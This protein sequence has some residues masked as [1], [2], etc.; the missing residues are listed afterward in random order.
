MRIALLSH[1]S[2]L[3]TALVLA[4]G[5]LTACD[6]SPVV[7]PAPSDG[8]AVAP[9]VVAAA[10]LTQPT[11]PTAIA[12][13][14]FLQPIAPAP[15]AL[16]TPDTS[17]LDLL[18]VEICAH[19]GAICTP[20][21]TLD[22][23]SRRS[24]RLRLG[25]RGEYRTVWNTNGD[26]FGPG[27]YRIRVLASGGEIGHADVEIVDPRAGDRGAEAEWVRI[28]RKSS[29]PIS[30]V[31]EEGV[32]QRQGSEGGR[33]EL[34]NGRIALDIP[35]GALT[36]D[37]FFTATP[38]LN[39]PTNDPPLIP[40][41]AWDFGPDGLVFAQPVT[42][43]IAYDPADLP[44]GIDEA[45]LRIHELVDGAFVQQNAGL[46]D[47]VNKT[48][49]AE[50]DGF[51]IF[52]VIPR[53]PRSQQDAEVATVR[54]VEVWDAAAGAYATNTSIDVGPSDAALRIRL[55]ITDDVSGVRFVDVRYRSPTGRQL[56]FP[57][58][59]GAAP[60][61]GSDT[62]G[63]WICD[64][65]FPR[66]AE[67]GVWQAE[68]V[69]ITDRANNAAF[70]ASGPQGFCH[71]PNFCVANPATVTV[72]SA[73]PD[74]TPPVLQ[75]MEVSA[76]SG[77]RAFGPMLSVDA[78]TGPVPVVF[79]LQV[80]DDLS[81]FVNQLRFDAVDFDLRGP[82]G[83]SRR[84]Y[85]TCQLTSGTALDG[86][87]ECF[88]TVPGQ[89]EPGD[90]G[91]GGI[92]VPDRAGNGGF[93]FFSYF[94]PD[95]SG[96]LCNQTG[97]CVIAPVVRVVGAGDGSPPD[98]QSLTITPSGR[99]VTT[100]LGITDDLAGVSFARV[101]YLSATTGQ[102]QECFASLASGSQTNGTYSCTISFPDFAASGQWTL[103]LQLVDS[104][105]NERW[106]YRRA[107]DGFLCYW[108]PSTTTQ[109]C[110]D[111][112]STDLILN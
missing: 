89:A 69:F 11:A 100:D 23:G 102:S 29:L 107:S 38:V 52:V 45:E 80:T 90:W 43:T 87:L 73:T 110:Q 92:R 65:S 83:Q 47:L 15:S 25:G 6:S 24:A 82:S 72:V 4:T 20:V 62:N 106:Y 48:V 31:V 111:F 109:V 95:G 10:P 67:P 98:L 50:V 19:T 105:G 99:D 49:S 9:P 59:T 58:Y 14:H 70:Y 74:L 55:T 94:S 56:R 108:D 104:A 33:V 85:G 8:E 18:E 35:A 1:T 88:A 26:E 84:S 78:S 3:A 22:A 30:F 27:F 42:M 79:G 53:D 96:Q 13:V 2:R 34:L 32:G 12:G 51:S 112:G 40:G 41:T 103:T 57:C 16:G 39:P 44:P 101:Q 28:T 93:S 86:F 54:A 36:A 91:I 75:S 46:V 68:L 77:P 97:N 37:V 5:L 21:L 81:G 66:Y 64:S 63:Q 7:P 71:D 17:L 60:D 76:A 61:V